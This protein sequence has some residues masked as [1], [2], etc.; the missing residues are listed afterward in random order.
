MKVYTCTDSRGITLGPKTTWISLL[1]EQHK[2]IDIIYNPGWGSFGTLNHYLPVFEREKDF[3]DVTII[4]LGYHD[5]CIPWIASFFQGLEDYDPDYKNH[6]IKFE[7]G[8]IGPT[9]FKNTYRYR[10]DEAIKHMFSLYRK[11]TKKL[12]WLSLPYQW[13]EFLEQTKVVNELFGSCCD[14]SVILPMDPDFPRR[15]TFNCGIDKVH[16]LDFYNQEI[17][18]MVYEKLK[19]MEVN[20]ESS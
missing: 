13:E 11:K 16:Y 2:D 3:F 17:A 8:Y 19:T 6:L 1:K 20:L 15:C 14:E 9:F 18:N 12:L 7:D 5:Y 4:Q 10:N